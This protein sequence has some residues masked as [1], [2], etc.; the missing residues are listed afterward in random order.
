[1]ETCRVFVSS[2]AADLKEH[3]AKVT[4]TIL[5][6]EQVPVAMKFFGARPE[7]PLAE[8]VRLA[9]TADALVVIVAHRYGWRP[10]PAQGGDGRKSVTWYEVEAALKAAKPVF[11]FL[12]DP[13]APWTQP[14][15]QEDAAAQAALDEFKAFLEEHIIVQVFST[16]E[17]LRAW[18]ATSL[19]SWLIRR[20]AGN[21]KPDAYGLAL[22]ELRQVHRYVNAAGDFELEVSYT[23]SN[24]TKWNVAL[25]LPDSVSF[26]VADPEALKA[27][28]T[29]S[30]AATGEHAKVVS[31]S[32]EGPSFT[33]VKTS[34]LN[35]EEQS[36]TR[37]NWRAKVKPALSP[38]FVLS[39]KCV[40]AT[41]GT[42]KLAFSDAGSYLGFATFYP[43]KRLS[44]VGKAPPGYRFDREALVPFRTTEDGS[45]VDIAGLPQP[46]LQADDR[47]LTWS[48]AEEAVEIVVNY[49]LRFRFVPIEASA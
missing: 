39:Y 30:C 18:V 40:I 1:M 8:C 46:V 13:S 38:E 3:R 45:I 31:L 22:I 6:L 28:T 5:Q 24:E 9:A 37:I 2:T 4:D 44:L 32:L 17:D 42:E 34:K 47:V 49:M 19:A 36:T 15:E 20:V 25:L 14:G 16:P 27:V 11:A 48:L 21:L 12:V 10:T 23:V 43:T 41:K 26:L 7:A 29:V 35:G 33:A